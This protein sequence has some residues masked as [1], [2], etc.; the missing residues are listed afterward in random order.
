MDW[1]WRSGS[2]S[3]SG[4]AWGPTPPA[5]GGGKSEWREVGLAG[6]QSAVHFQ[7]L[8]QC[9]VDTRK[10]SFLAGAEYMYLQLFIEFETPQVQAR[11]R[12]VYGRRRY[13]QQ[14]FD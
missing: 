13:G 14:S 11:Q 9:C 2:E 3:E 1:S 10:R 5:G 8:L 6:C 12:L 4:V 7:A